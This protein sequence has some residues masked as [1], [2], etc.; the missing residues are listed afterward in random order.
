MFFTILFVFGCKENAFFSNSRRKYEIPLKLTIA[1]G[2][3]FREE[4]LQRGL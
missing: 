1:K 4:T 3:A 2:I